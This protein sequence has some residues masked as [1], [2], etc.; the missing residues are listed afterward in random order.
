M[1]RRH[2]HQVH[3]AAGLSVRHVNAI[4][5]TFGFVRPDQPTL[6]QWELM[7][8][9]SIALGFKLLLRYDDLKRCRYD[10]GYCEVHYSYVRFYLDGRK[11]NQ[12]GGNFLDVARPVDPGVRGVY[13]L[14]VLAKTIFGSGFVLFGVDA[15]GVLN[16]AVSM[17]HKAFVAHLREALVNVGL[18]REMAEVFS[19]HS[20]RAGG[21]T[22]AAAMG[23]HREDIVHLAG[24]KDPNRLAYYNRNYLAER[25]R[26]SRAIGL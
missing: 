2:A 7:V 9:T 13:H 18:T 23:L 11:N 19:A 26:V 25:L 10:S 6:K 4:M 12:Y 3:K 17:A 21:A 24:V 1:R 16:P 20:M 22:S 15:G 14:C 8:G 5:D